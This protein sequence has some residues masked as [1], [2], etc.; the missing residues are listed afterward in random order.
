MKK[1]D[2][3]KK[4]HLKIT[5]FMVIQAVF[6][7]CSVGVLGHGLIISVEKSTNNS[8]LSPHLNMNS[9]ELQHTIK[10]YAEANKIS[11][12]LAEIPKQAP[13]AQSAVKENKFNYFLKNAMLWLVLSWGVVYG[14][15]FFDVV[16]AAGEGIKMLITEKVIIG[17]LLFSGGMIFTNYIYMLK[18]INY[19]SIV[20]SF[21]FVNSLTFRKISQ[22][23]LSLISFGLINYY[24]YIPYYF[25]GNS[26]NS[27]PYFDFNPYSLL[28]EID[29][30]WLNDFIVFIGIALGL[31][32]TFS[33]I[34]FVGSAV[35]KLGSYSRIQSIFRMLRIEPDLST[36]ILRILPWSGYILFSFFSAWVLLA[37]VG[38]ELLQAGS[39]LN[40]GPATAKEIGT[41]DWG[42]MIAYLAGFFSA[43]KLMSYLFSQNKKPALEMNESREIEILSVNNIPK[44][45]SDK[46]TL[47][48]KELLEGGAEENRLLKVNRDN[49]KINL[50]EDVFS[51]PALQT[52]LSIN[53]TANIIIIEQ[54]I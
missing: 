38:N 12:N 48:K 4:I 15:S 18:N 28:W 23:A 53:S 31:Y 36:K 35:N 50:L 37:E 9:L 3:F 49:Q 14:L 51:G 33:T 2:N 27:N 32:L 25:S 13:N 39:F 44:E 47:A 16:N 11:E 6:L 10:Q 8:M 17:G 24:R 30:Y 46:Y 45:V 5:A 22:F 42:D 52:N 54:A 34:Y 40:V 21:D 19:E 43:K 41:F 20:S 1:L 26:I 29:H 7:S